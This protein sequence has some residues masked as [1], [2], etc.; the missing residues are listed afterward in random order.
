M[1]GQPRELSG[2]FLLFPQVGD[3]CNMTTELT[4]SKNVS[5]EKCV[6][7][8]SVSEGSLWMASSMGKVISFGTLATHTQ[9]KL[10]SAHIAHINHDS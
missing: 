9:V 6:L 4:T 3:Q 1:T 2:D 10:V 5:L 8:G 7:K